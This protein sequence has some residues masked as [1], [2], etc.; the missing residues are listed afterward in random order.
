[1]KVA[2][3]GGS[4]NPPHVAHVLVPVLVRATHDVDRV[5]VVPTF[6]HPFAKDLAPY[7]DRV[8]MCELAMAGA[9]DVEVSRVE[10]ELGGESRTLRTLEHLAAKH[11]DWRMRLVVGSDILAEA[12]RWFGFEAIQTLAPLV[13]LHRAGIDAPA[14]G[15]V[16][17]PEISSTQVRGAIGRGAWGEIEELVPRGVVAYIRE[18]RLY[19]A[20]A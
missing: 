14:A 16:L 17:L 8:R 3:F 10:E 5:L 12:P 15:K 9:C 20:P 13:V 11:P 4:F 7:D 19:G 6:R 1:M 18:K 2:V